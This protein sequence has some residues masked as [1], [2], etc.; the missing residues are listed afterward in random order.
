[1]HHGALEGKIFA[2]PVNALARRVAHIRVHTFNGT[3]LLCAYWYSVFRGDVTC[4]D[5]SFYMKFEAEKLGYPRRNILLDRIDTHLN[6]AG[7]HVQ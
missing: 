2:Y 3:N 5:M 7:R 1:M 6:Q 4:M